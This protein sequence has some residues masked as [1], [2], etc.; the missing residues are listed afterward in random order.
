MTMSRED[1]A[2]GQV[3]VTQVT[4]GQ[5]SEQTAE[6]RLAGVHFNGD[7]GQG[8]CDGSGGHE[9]DDADDNFDDDNFILNKAD[10]CTTATDS[11]S[12][13]VVMN[14]RDGG[15]VM[16]ERTSGNDQDA[17]VMTTSDVSGAC[18]VQASHGQMNTDRCYNTQ[19]DNGGLKLDV[20]DASRDLD[21][22]ASRDCHSDSN[23]SESRDTDS[24]RPRDSDLS[25]CSCVTGEQGSLTKPTQ[26]QHSEVDGE[27]AVLKSH[28]VLSPPEPDEDITGSTDSDAA[29]SVPSLSGDSQTLSDTA[30]GQGRDLDLYRQADKDAVC[31]ERSLDAVGQTDVVTTGVDVQVSP[32]SLDNQCTAC[33]LSSVGESCEQAPPRVEDLRQ[34][35]CGDSHQSVCGD[36]QRSLLDSEQKVCDSEQSECDSQQC[37]FIDSQQSAD[38]KPKQSLFGDSQ[39]SI[40]G[41][42]EQSVCDSQQDICDPLISAE[43]VEKED[44]A[45]SASLSDSDNRHDDENAIADGQDDSSDSD[46]QEVKTHHSDLGEAPAESEGSEV[47]ST[48]HDADSSDGKLFTT[49]IIT[50]DGDAVE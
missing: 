34:T 10:I 7:L 20:S 5:E 30:E 11:A 37:V 33:D 27:S 4:Q 6:R 28:A 13:H 29:R 43:G 48:R 45:A 3:E 14:G 19:N 46:F 49:V 35:I 38:G 22:V 18:S 23:R 17:A 16:T 36:T 15:D 41:G 2:R 25:G 24:R 12:C 31:P 44:R 9:C 1:D 40:P 42:S 21:D 39:R 32:S 47:T 50:S 8:D 26:A